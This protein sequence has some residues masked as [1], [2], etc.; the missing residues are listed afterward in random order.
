MLYFAL[1]RFTVLLYVRVQAPFTFMGFWTPQHIYLKAEV[2]YA[3]FK[4][5]CVKL[6]H[7]AIV[8][9]PRSAGVF[10]T[11]TMSKFSEIMKRFLLRVES[12]NF[13]SEKQAT[14]P[15]IGASLCTKALFAMLF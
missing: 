3:F 10:L 6:F 7:A 14:G 13:F 8:M 9:L 4:G 11:I 5:L 2:E 12:L 1:A 15:E